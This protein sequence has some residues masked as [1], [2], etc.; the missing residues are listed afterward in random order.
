MAP[1]FF[2]STTRCVPPI[3]FIAIILP[4]ASLSAAY[5][6]GFS[7][8][9]FSWPLYIS[10]EGPQ[11]S[12]QIASPWYLLSNGFLYSTS[13]LS[14]KG[15]SSILVLILSY[16]T[17]S[18]TVNLGPQSVHALKGYLYLLSLGFLISAKHLSQ[19]A[20]SGGITDSP[21]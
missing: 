9:T 6:I 5:L 17:V 3:P 1:L 16:G 4:S 10:I 20:T 21:L 7:L 19:I 2:A 11:S 15:K 14:H 13:H 8:S 12:Q 18:I